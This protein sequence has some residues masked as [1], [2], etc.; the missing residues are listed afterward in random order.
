MTKI[1]IKKLF[2]TFIS[3]FIVRVVGGLLGAVG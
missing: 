3:V 1:A 2:P